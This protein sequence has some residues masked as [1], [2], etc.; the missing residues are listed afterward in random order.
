MNKRIKVL[1]EVKLKGKG[2]N[3]FNYQYID[4]DGKPISATFQATKSALMGMVK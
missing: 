1:G 2:T 3:L 4:Q